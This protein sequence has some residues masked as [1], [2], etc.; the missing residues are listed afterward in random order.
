MNPKFDRERIGRLT[1]CPPRQ[2][3]S[4]DKIDNKIGLVIS[5]WRLGSILHNL[6]HI[7]PSHGQFRGGG[8]F[9]RQISSNIF[10]CNECGNKSS[11]LFL[12][13]VKRKWSFHLLVLPKFLWLHAVA[14]AAAATEVSKPRVKIYNLKPDPLQSCSLAHRDHN[15]ATKLLDL[16]ICD[17]GGSARKC[18][19]V[20]SS[21][22]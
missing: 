2:A 22:R 3:P 20:S 21:Q 16:K 12:Q 7:R 13:C 6:V 10:F 18:G 5:I 15:G 17:S 1:M 11:E 4:N 14:T 9:S 8:K 19:S